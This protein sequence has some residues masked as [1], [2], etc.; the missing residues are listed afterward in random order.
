MNIHVKAA[1]LCIL[2]IF[3]GLISA[4]ECPPKPSV[5]NLFS[6]SNKVYLGMKINF[7]NNN[8]HQIVYLEGGCK[9]RYVFKP[10][11]NVLNKYISGKN[12]PLKV[13][14]CV[15]NKFINEENIKLDLDSKIICSVSDKI[16]C[17]FLPSK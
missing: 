10:S 1:I 11:D 2:V 12:I 5:C 13:T 4:K 8:P 3:S 15:N 17:K 9:F 6:L 7:L 16:T 14:F